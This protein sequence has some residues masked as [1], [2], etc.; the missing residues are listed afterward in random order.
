MNIGTERR[1]RKEIQYY[2]VHHRKC[3]I[4]IGLD[5]TGGDTTTIGPFK[6]DGDS[7]YHRVFVL[8]T[9]SDMFK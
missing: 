6:T 2:E 8:R 4:T 3:P 1:R 7:G 9:G 5:R